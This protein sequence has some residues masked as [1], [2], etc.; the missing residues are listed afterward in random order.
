MPA[1]GAASPAAETV[2]RVEDA[3]AT[4]APTVDASGT[5]K[6]TWSGRPMTLKIKGAT[7]E[8]EVLVGTSYRTWQLRG[9]V[10]PDGRFEYA[11]GEGAEAWWVSGT[12]KDG[13]LS[14]SARSGSGGKATGFSARRR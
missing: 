1:A 9:G 10:Q 13:Q 5:W 6:G 4:A 3:A 7:A 8:L 2:T 11:G 12:V 14:G